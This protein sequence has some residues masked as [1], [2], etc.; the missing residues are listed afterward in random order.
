MENNSKSIKEWSN[1]FNPFNSDKYISQVPKWSTIEYRG[2]VP[3]PTTISIDPVNTCNLDCIWCNAEEIIHQGHPSMTRETL[4]EIAD[5]L[6]EWPATKKYPKKG[7]EAL[8]LSGGGE[9]LL[10]PA[11]GEF[12]R[13]CYDNGV[14][15]ALV[16]NGVYLN[17]HL[18][19]IAECC[20]WAGISVDAGTAET[21]KKL[22]GKDR[23]DKVI[24]NIETLIHYSKEHNTTLATPG[25]GPGVGYKY[26]L[27]P[28]NVQDVYQAAKIAKEIGCKSI[29]IRPFGTPWFK[30]GERNFDEENL[31]IFRE[32][33][34]KAREL[35]FDDEYGGFRVYGI[36]HK[37]SGDFSPN[38][39]FE[40]C[41]S[42]ILTGVLMPPSGEGKF[43]YGFC[44]DRRG[45]PNVTKKNLKDMNDFYKFWGSKE[46]WDMYDK[47]PK[48]ESCPRCT[49]KPH[50]QI[51]DQMCK[52]DNTT[53]EFI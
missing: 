52:K 42:P 7:V 6:P 48:P 5:M 9:N 3:P 46:F 50:I 37:F 49:L 26:L 16:T 40:K 25:L 28:G 11:A 23:F 43:D 36:T 35:E 17:R 2:E 44:F 53:Y 21:Y 31:Q 4:M 22:K 33:I 27:H 20:T 1:K 8:C 19:D 24:N 15:T 41:H 10:H 51:Y 32:Q 18:S 38:N 29:H 39:N 34:I 14:K 47:T 13:R 30:E 45:D 12:L